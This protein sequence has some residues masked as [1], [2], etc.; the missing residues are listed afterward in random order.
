MMMKHRYKCKKP[1]TKA[2]RGFMV[3]CITAI[4]LY[5]L[6]GILTVT[7]ADNRKLTTHP[8]S[9]LVSVLDRTL[10]VGLEVKRTIQPPQG[11]TSLSVFLT[12]STNVP[13]NIPS[14]PVAFTIDFD[15]PQVVRSNNSPTSWSAGAASYPV[16]TL[17]SGG[18]AR[19]INYVSYCPLLLDGRRVGNRLFNVAALLHVAWRTGRRAAIPTNNGY[20]GED[21][22][23]GAKKYD[24][25]IDEI[26]D[27]LADRKLIERAGYE[28]ICE[29]G[30]SAW[31]GLVSMGKC[32]DVIEEHS[33]VYDTQWESIIDKNKNKSL[34]LCG[35]F[36]SWKYFKGICQFSKQ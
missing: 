22:Q 3:V 7:D 19:N 36:Q 10:T 29:T 21:D 11:N 27:Q 16:A 31:N 20:Y 33:M 26:F 15:L 35:Y 2:I 30:M 14:S 18:Q 17:E 8:T 32:A 25:H 6:W 4:L 5:R 13:D 28:V 23:S 24:W 1:S 12:A 34:L 9:Q